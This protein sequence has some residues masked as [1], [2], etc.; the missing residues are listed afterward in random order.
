MMVEKNT[1]CTNLDPDLDVWLTAELNAAA[2]KAVSVDEYVVLRDSVGDR[3][4][5]KIA[6][7]SGAI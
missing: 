5:E 4:K 6:A 3:L 7:R 1:D 2:R